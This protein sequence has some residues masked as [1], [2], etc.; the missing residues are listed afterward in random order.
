V[1]PAPTPTSVVPPPREPDQD[2]DGT[3]DHYDNS[4]GDSHGNDDV[5]PRPNTWE[6][7]KTE[8]SDGDTYEDYYDGDRKDP[9]EH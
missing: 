5:D 1:S 6:P 9:Y 4:D 2:N 7:S 8:D 3:P